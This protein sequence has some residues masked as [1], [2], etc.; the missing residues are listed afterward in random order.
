VCAPEKAHQSKGWA[1]DE[2]LFLMTNAPAA[3]DG[4]VVGDTAAQAE[5]M[6]GQLFARELIADTDGV[7]WQRGVR[8]LASLFPGSDGSIYGAASNDRQAAFRRAPNG[9]TGVGGLFLASGSAHPG[10]GVPLCAQSGWMAAAAVL[11]Q[12]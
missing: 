1:T 9:V 2:P 8:E 10:G 11:S 7:V 4:V 12:P 5:H 6:R 3:T